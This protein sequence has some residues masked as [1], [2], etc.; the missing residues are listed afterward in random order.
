MTCAPIPNIPTRSRASAGAVGLALAVLSMAAAGPAAA[1]GEAEE[2]LP[3]EI[4]L[5][6]GA[7]AAVSA[8]HA[9]KDL[10]S[11]RMPGFLL[12]G[13]P[14][15]DRRHG[16]L[17][18]GLIE[19]GVR[20]NPQWG[21]YLG[22]GKHGSSAPHFEG[23]WVQW[24]PA[25][26]W[27]LVAGRQKPAL[28]PVWSGAGHMDRFALMPLAKQAAFLGDWIEDGVQ[29]GWRRPVGSG[30]LG[31]ELGVWRG[32]SWPGGFGGPAAVSAHVQWSQGDW[33]LDGFALHAAPRRR[34]TQITLT[35]ADHS[36]G[37]A[38]CDAALT[39]V[40]C[41]NGKVLVAGASARWLSH[42]W[43]VSASAAWLW[44]REWGELA[45]RNGSGDHRSAT[46]GG[47]I[48]GAWIFLPRWELGLRLEH[49][50][51]RQ[52]LTGPGAALVA[53]ELGWAAYRP[54]RRA[55]VSLG[56]Q[57]TDAV[58]LRLEAGTE[59]VGGQRARFAALRVLM[60]VSG[61]VGP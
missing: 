40:V 38:D 5:R 22:A 12:N 47:W 37:A 11:R 29:A 58:T 21:M 42:D 39:Q 10:P 4:G 14:A 51:A 30:D 56:W 13:S 36:H 6:L 15:E 19:A 2:S 25:P 1:H 23:A 27:R 49:L 9:S 52:R 35:G 43:P 20:I 46:L 48:E 8:L 28:G 33:T 61:I 41:F 45:S 55:A 7:A 57:P 32:Q 16:Q 54:A 44:R 18:H 60:A 34:G 3:E 53:D 59:S 31:A 24:Q 26:D 17:E 50:R